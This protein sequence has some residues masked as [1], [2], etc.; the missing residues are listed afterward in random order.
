MSWIKGTPMSRVLVTGAAGFI[1]SHLVDRLL[2]EGREVV[3]VDAFTGYYSRRTK[4][5]NLEGALGHERFRLVEGDLLG[6]GPRRGARRR[7]VRR[8]PRGGA[9]GAPELGSELPAVPGAQRTHHGAAARGRRPQAAGTRFVYASS[10]SVYG[11]DPGGRSARTTR[12]ACLP[13]RAL[14]ARRRGARGA[15]RGGSGAFRGRSCGTSPSTG[16][17]SGRR[18]RSRGSCSPRSGAGRSDVFGDGGQQRDMTYVSDAVEATVAALGAP[19][20]RLQRRGREPG[21]PCGR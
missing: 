4:E 11:P 14:Q 21:P 12:G 8:A 17:A 19:C 20:G 16:R 9:G 7:R 13:L 2:A 3:G 18:W 1:G 10:S 15:V 5:R 6:P